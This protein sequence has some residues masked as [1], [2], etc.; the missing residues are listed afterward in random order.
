[1]PMPLHL[2][3]VTTLPGNDNWRYWLMLL[4]MKG[5]VLIALFQFFHFVK[6]SSVIRLIAEGHPNSTINIMDIWEPHVKL[7]EVNIFF[8][9]SQLY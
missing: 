4:S 1:M 9:D 2:Y 8:S 5:S 7:D 6:F 3:S